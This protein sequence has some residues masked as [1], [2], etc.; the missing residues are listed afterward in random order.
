MRLARRSTDR[1]A[2]HWKSDRRRDESLRGRR[3]RIQVSGRMVRSRSFFK[4]MKWLF[5]SSML[6]GAVL[7][8]LIVSSTM[9]LLDTARH[10]GPGI[11]YYVGPEW[12]EKVPES[13]YK[14]HNYVM[15]GVTLSIGLML[16][17][18]VAR[19]YFRRRMRQGG[20]QNR[21]GRPNI[22]KK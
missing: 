15:F 3:L 10:K 20:F 13:Q 4:Q 7:G 16:W 17:F 22:I 14:R 19:A 1:M 6:W 5:N 11:V 12:S 2:G 21:F 18:V 9:H 8:W